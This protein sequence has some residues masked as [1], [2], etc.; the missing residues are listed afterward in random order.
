MSKPTVALILLA[1]LLGACNTVNVPI[2]N[3]ESV[4]INNPDTARTPKPTAAR[5]T[6]GKSNNSFKYLS[7]LTLTNG[8]C[9]ERDPSSYGLLMKQRT[10]M[11]EGN[12]VCYYN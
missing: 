3:A 7:K 5:V 4:T 8:P 12:I 1:G 11:I 2:Q 9:P 10:T 6:S